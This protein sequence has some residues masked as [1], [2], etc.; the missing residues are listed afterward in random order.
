M[1]EN[2]GKKISVGAKLVRAF[3]IGQTIGIIGGIGLYL[4][5]LAVNT[6]AS[7][8]IIDPI[9]MLLLTDGMATV[10]SIGVELSKDIA[11]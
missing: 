9:S 3:F 11:E 4:L 1:S 7:S 10:A 6:L 8:T 2:K 5:T